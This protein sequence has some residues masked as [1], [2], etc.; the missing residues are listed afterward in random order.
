MSAAEGFFDTNIL[1]YVL[2]DDAMKADRAE[3][4]IA[5]GG[6]ISVQV[7]NEF[8]SVASRKSGLKIAQI[9]EILAA[10]RSACVVNSVDIATHERG[11]DLAARYGFSIYDAL[12]V[13]AALNA[14]CKVLYSEDMQAGQTIEG[15]TIRNPFRE[16]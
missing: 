9:R 3:E 11:L 4:L 1:L 16:S 15:L 13:A 8:V 14:G 7:L 12:I 10:I 2:S 5:A 6:T